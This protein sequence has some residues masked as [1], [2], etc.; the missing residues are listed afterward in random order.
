M[1]ALKRALKRFGRD[2]GHE[3]ALRSLL[4]SI[5]PERSRTTRS[6]RSASE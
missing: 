5:R 6:Q 3:T 1:R 2:A 4:E